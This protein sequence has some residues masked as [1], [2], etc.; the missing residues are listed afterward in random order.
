MYSGHMNTFEIINS[1][2]G[3]VADWADSHHEAEGV[4]SALTAKTKVLHFVP[5]RQG[6]RVLAF[7]V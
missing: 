7:A 6:E 5:V 4:A 1:E 2:T 3:A